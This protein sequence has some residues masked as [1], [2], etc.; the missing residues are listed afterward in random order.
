MNTH[1]S[2]QSL[3][4]QKQINCLLSY[5]CVCVHVC[6][7]ARVHD[8]PNPSKKKKPSSNSAINMAQCHKHGTVP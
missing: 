2:C 4:S 7:C 5:I 6:T 1:Q 3:S 8:N